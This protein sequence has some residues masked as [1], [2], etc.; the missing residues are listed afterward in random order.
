MDD[1]CYVELRQKVSTPA[2]RQDLQTSF[3]AVWGLEC[4]NCATRVRNQLIAL[5]GVVSA[6]VDHTVG[7]A[8]VDFNSGLTS[9]PALLEAVR[10]AGAEGRHTYHAHV[11]EGPLGLTGL[12]P[13]VL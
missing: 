3:L 11:W 4:V 7:L 12:A 8:Q 5:P 1:N 6:F 13:L 2:E 10:L 9:V